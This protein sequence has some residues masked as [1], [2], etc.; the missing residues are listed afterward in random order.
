LDAKLR[1]AQLDVSS[2]LPLW[3]R[4]V[5]GFIERTWGEQWKRFDAV[6]LVGGGIK[7]LKNLPYRF[8]GKAYVPDQPVM[9][10]AR[11]L[12]KLTLMTLGRKKEA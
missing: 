9:S 11:G 6:L 12:E 5:V 8:N 2:A 4:E 1:G 10:I 3:E 7:L